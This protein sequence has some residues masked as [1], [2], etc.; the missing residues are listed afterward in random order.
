MHYP[1]YQDQW[2][3][4]YLFLKNK[5]NGG[6]YNY[7]SSQ[8]ECLNFLN[9][10]ITLQIT[11]ISSALMDSFLMFSIP[12][13]QFQSFNQ[14]IPVAYIESAT[15]NSYRFSISNFRIC[16]VFLLS[17]SSF[18]MLDFVFLNASFKSVNNL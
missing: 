9:F 7:I 11:S 10:L 12:F 4:G 8:A 2:A 15:L 13:K 17:S 6:I 3:Y 16:K 18:R 14:I 5:S 1:A